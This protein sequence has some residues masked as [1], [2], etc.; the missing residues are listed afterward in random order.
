[1]VEPLPIE[2]TINETDGDNQRLAS[3]LTSHAT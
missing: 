1:M 2:I 3:T